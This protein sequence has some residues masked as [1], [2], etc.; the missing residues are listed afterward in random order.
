M[1]FASIKLTIFVAVSL[2]VSALCCESGWFGS[3]C[4]FKC[5]CKTN[6][7][8]ND[9]GVC[10]DG[11]A[12]G[13]FGHKCQYVDSDLPLHQK[14]YTDDGRCD[15]KQK[16]SNKFLTYYFMW[17]R[18]TFEDLIPAYVSIYFRDQAMRN[19]IDCKNYYISFVDSKTFDYF[20][21]PFLDIRDMYIFSNFGT[22]AVCKMYMSR[23]RNLA[24]KQQTENSSTVDGDRTSNANCF[25]TNVWSLSLTYPS[26]INNIVIYSVKGKITLVSGDVP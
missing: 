10:L 16:E 8:C 4:E 19:F 17:A 13:Y 23:G 21:E 20:C 25:L 24:L 15:F 7:D 6:T 11:C 3:R 9:R 18:F 5:H 14:Q 1:A 12:D 2:S 26:S 22:A